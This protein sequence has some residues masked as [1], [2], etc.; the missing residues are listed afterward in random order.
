[1][2][3]AGAAPLD[4]VLPDEPQNRRQTPTE[5]GVRLTEIYWAAAAVAGALLLAE[6]FAILRE[7]R[8][9]RSVDVEALQ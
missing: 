2:D 5:A 7:F 9:T 3:R 6:L 8:R 4:T 1:L